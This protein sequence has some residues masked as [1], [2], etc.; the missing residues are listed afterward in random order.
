LGFADQDRGASVLER[1]GRGEELQF[2][3]HWP[4]G[5]CDLQDGGEALSQRDDVSRVL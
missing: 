5:N 4:S 2:E 3:E 1:A